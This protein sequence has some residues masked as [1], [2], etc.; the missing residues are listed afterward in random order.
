M[1]DYEKPLVGLDP[2]VAP[3]AA[4]VIDDRHRAPRVASLHG[5]VVGLISNGK[6]KATSFLTALYDELARL[7]PLA[8]QVMV[9][10]PAVYAIPSAEDWTLLTSQ[11]TVGVTAFGG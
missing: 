6:G 4:G 7:A 8:G 3:A 9:E 11:A 10:K 1:A 2:T 5:A